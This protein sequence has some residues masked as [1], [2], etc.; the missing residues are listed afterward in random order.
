MCY[1]CAVNIILWWSRIPCAAHPQQEV[2]NCIVPNKPY[3]PFVT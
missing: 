1:Y 3:F 2:A